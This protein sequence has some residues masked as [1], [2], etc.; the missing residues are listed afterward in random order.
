MR[1]RTDFEDKDF[2]FS[3]NI[4][5]EDNG[6]G[7]DTAK[8]YEGLGLKNIQSRV[9]FLKGKLNIDRDNGTT[10]TI[11]IDLNTLK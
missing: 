3:I 2:E 5:V 6:I 11:D 9:T 1:S 10:V 8:N 4:T 7:F